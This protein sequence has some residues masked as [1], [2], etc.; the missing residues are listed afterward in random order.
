MDADLSDARLDRAKDVWRRSM[1]IANLGRT[2]AEFGHCTP[3]PQ[4]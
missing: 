3:N 1:S 2:Y 4:Q